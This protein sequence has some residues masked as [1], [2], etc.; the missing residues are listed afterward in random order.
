M[1]SFGGFGSSL[2]VSNESASAVTD[3][4]LGT[5]VFAV[6]LYADFAVDTAL[7]FSGLIRQSEKNVNIIVAFLGDEQNSLPP[8]M[9]DDLHKGLRDLLTL[10]DMP[11]NW[12]ICYFDASTAPQ[13]LIIRH[14]IRG[15]V[16][17]REVLEPMAILLRE[18]SLPWSFKV[19]FNE[20]YKMGLVEGPR[21]MQYAWGEEVHS[22]VL[23]GNT[24]TEQRTE[25]AIEPEKL[26]MFLLD[27]AE[28][29]EFPILISDKHFSLIPLSGGEVFFAGEGF[30]VILSIVIVGT[31]LILFLIYSAKYNAFFYFNA[32]LILKNIWIFLLLL[33]LLVFSIRVS[34][35]LYYYLIHSLYAPAAYTNFFGAFLTI[36]LAA[37]I[38][39]LPSPLLNFIRFP[40]RAQFYGFSAVFII[41]LGIITSIFMDFSYILVFLWAFIFVFL[42]AMFSRPLVVILCALM[43]PLLAMGLLINILSTGGSE[44]TGLLISDNW[45]STLNWITAIET[46]LLILPMILII[47]RGII[48]SQKNKKTGHETEPDRKYR[49]IIL[50]ILIL[51]VLGT[52]IMQ[53]SLISI[54]QFNPERREYTTIDDAVVYLSLDDTIFQNT[55]I[56]KLM[57]AAYGNPL[58]FD[59]VLESN[60]SESLLPLYTSQIPYERRKDR[61]SVV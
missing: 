47:I 25:A 45:S 56:I 1:T 59:L 15:Y 18:H 21:V 54:F 27:Y 42:G 12:V 30:I 60:N 20:I 50:P 31:F 40:R 46:A 14:G 41:L 34:A 5:F 32:R 58:R 51:I 44:F 22:L 49:L 36:I 39:F 53:L 10:T 4:A 26:A 19:W 35:L 16:S 29:L 17:P 9:G 3:A 23:S 37:L 55:K 57:L 6:P 8:D 13:S 61:K 24:Q 7:A 38:F 28:A 48:L 2:L 52:M 33:P 11:E 43:I